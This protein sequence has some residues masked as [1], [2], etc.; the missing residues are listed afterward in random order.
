MALRISSNYYAAGGIVGGVVV[1]E[2]DEDSDD[3][4]DPDPE[5]TTTAANAVVVGNTDDNVSTTKEESHRIDG[6]ENEIEENFQPQILPSMH[7]I[8]NK[9]END[10]NSFNKIS[11]CEQ[12]NIAEAMPTSSTV[13]L[14]QS[15]DNYVI[16]ENST[17]ECSQPVIVAGGDQH[18][19][20]DDSSIQDEIETVDVVPTASINDQMNDRTSS[21]NSGDTGDNVN[22]NIQEVGINVN[23]T[24]IDNDNNSEANVEC[25][26]EN[27]SK[28]ETV[29]YMSATQV[30]QQQQRE[31]QLSRSVSRDS[32]EHEDAKR[33]HFLQ[34]GRAT[35]VTQHSHSL[36]NLASK[37]DNTSLN[38]DRLSNSDRGKNS[39]MK[40]KPNQKQ[41]KISLHQKSVHA[42]QQL[43]GNSYPNL[44]IN[45]RGGD[46]KLVTND[47]EDK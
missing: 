30:L 47:N 33:R 19:I 44:N 18:R 8:D 15:S 42:R 20:P 40:N 35:L 1:G 13:E 12:K 26:A 11:D 38:S 45:A 4:M 36:D 32:Q 27:G 22:A 2:G 23:Q 14:N 31:R 34:L 46:D 41:T 43:G 37:S 9:R 7:V 24:R 6:N 10:L 39:S 17:N 3:E 28:F 21:I 5:S 29:R 16:N 25:G